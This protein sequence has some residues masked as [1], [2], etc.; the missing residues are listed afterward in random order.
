M[1]K[2]FRSMTYPYVLWISVMIVVPM[3]LIASFHFHKE[4]ET[5][6]FGCMECVKHMHHDAHLTSGQTGLH[7]CVLCQFLSFTYLFATAA[8]LLLWPRH[9]VSLRH[10]EPSALCR[11]AVWH[12]TGRAPPMLFF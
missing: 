3:L 5:E 6:S 7:D 12:P 8:T 4:V 10:T 9:S 1:V 2:Q 11:C